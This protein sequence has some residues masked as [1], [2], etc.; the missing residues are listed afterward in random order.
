MRRAGAVVVVALTAAV[1]G[2]AQTPPRDQSK[3]IFAPG[4]GVVT[5]TVVID[6]EKRAPLRH[7]LVTLVRSGT[8]DMRSTATDDQGAYEF[9]AVPPGAYRLVAGKGAYVS[10]DYGSPKPGMPGLSVVLTEGQRLAARPIAL[11][12]GAVIGGRLLDANGSPVPN[13]LVQAAQFL[14]INGARSARL[15]TGAWAGS[16]TNAHGEYRIYGLL[17]GE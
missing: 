7:A 3:S 1:A 4:S 13:T 14:T 11:T 6:D 5:G 10:M 9:S 17:S 15:T 16:T 2:L 12:R 8:E